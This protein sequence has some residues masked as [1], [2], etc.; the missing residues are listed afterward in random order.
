MAGYVFHFTFQRYLPVPVIANRIPNDTAGVT[1]LTFENLIREAGS[2]ALYFYTRTYLKSEFKKQ[3]ENC[4]I[5][6]L[7]KAFLSV[8]TA[9]R[10]TSL[11]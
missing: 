4:E 5:L 8:V 6:N 2:L 9:G 11:W 7:M 10:I 1:V 3:N